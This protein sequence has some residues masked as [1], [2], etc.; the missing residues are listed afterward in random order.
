MFL[1]CTPKKYLILVVFQLFRIVFW[2]PTGQPGAPFL[3]KACILAYNNIFLLEVPKNRMFLY[4][5]PKKY[6]IFVVF[7]L[8][9]VVFLGPTGQPGAPFLF[10]ACIL[11]Y[12][13]IFFIKVPKNWTFLDCIPKNTS[14]Q[15]F[16]QLFL[17]VF[18]APM[19]QPG[20]PF[21]F[22]ACILAYNNI[23]FIKVPKNRMF[24]DCIPKN[25]S[26]Q[27]FFSYFWQ[28]F[29]SLGASLGLPFCSKPVFQHAITFSL[30]KFP[31][32]GCFLTVYPKNRSFQSYFGYFQQFFL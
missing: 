22:K 32:I 11:A 23:F 7:Q 3:L 31:R 27:S 20:A 18:W 29:G 2:V 21:L 5:I 4:C 16:F 17:V 30:L 12:N 19:D 24:L 13:N 14:F 28:F 25:T 26:F 8:F 15:S 6:L 1:D 9:L 10:K